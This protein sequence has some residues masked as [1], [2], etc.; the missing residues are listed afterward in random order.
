MLSFAGNTVTHLG[1]NEFIRVR[2]GNDL[3]LWNATFRAYDYQAGAQRLLSVIL[4]LWEAEM[5]RSP[6]VRS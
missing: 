2:E 5:G 6:E 1:S 3:G 4:P